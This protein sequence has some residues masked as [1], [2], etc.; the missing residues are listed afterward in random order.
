[1]YGEMY[2]PENAVDDFFDDGATSTIVMPI[3]ARIGPATKPTVE[4]APAR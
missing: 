2:A 1:M 4:S 3:A